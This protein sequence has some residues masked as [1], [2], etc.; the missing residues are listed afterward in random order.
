MSAPPPLRRALT[1]LVLDE[2]LD[3]RDAPRAAAARVS[4]PAAPATGS[5]SVKKQSR[6]T[7]AEESLL[8]SVL[9]APTATPTTELVAIA[10]KLGY[11]SV[12]P[13]APRLDA[14][15]CCE[16][17]L[18]LCHE[19]SSCDHSALLQQ[20]QANVRDQVHLLTNRSAY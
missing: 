4:V 5:G 20:L 3:G 16:Q 17:G 18:P 9:D 14:D 13:F 10:R 2:Q 12:L 8:L 7:V 11:R 15:G 6:L 19:E 1:R